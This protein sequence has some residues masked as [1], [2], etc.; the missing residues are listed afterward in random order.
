MRLKIECSHVL[1][2]GGQIT[3]VRPPSITSSVSANAT[4]IQSTAR[5]EGTQTA[6]G[7]GS[8]SHRLYDCGRRR[9]GADV[10]H[11]KANVVGRDGKCVRRLE[12]GYTLRVYSQ[13][14]SASTTGA[15]SYNVK[16]VKRAKLVYIDTAPYLSSNFIFVEEHVRNPFPVQVNRID[17]PQIVWRQRVEEGLSKKRTRNPRC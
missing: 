13:A 2:A 3:H 7:G 6:Y 5:G 15:R 11:V 4:G 16:I 14:S 12:R 17:R 9:S 10:K 8:A 1:F